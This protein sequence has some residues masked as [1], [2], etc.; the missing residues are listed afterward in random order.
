MVVKSRKVERQRPGHR[1]ASPDPVEV[2]GSAKPHRSKAWQWH[3]ALLL[4]AIGAIYGGFLDTPFVFDDWGHL[5]DGANLRKLTDGQVWNLGSRW[6]GS[7]TFAVNYA[8]HGDSVVGYHLVNVAIHMLAAVTLYAIVDWTL[9]TSPSC[10]AFRDQAAWLAFAVALLWSVHPLH[11]Q[12]VTYL[13]QR[14][15]SLASLFYLLAFWALLQTQ[16]STKPKRWYV[17]SWA[18]CFLSMA[19]KEIGATA[20]VMLLWFDRA[21]LAENWGEIR[22]RRWGYY[23]LLATVWLMPA[24][25]YGV[26]GQK[27]VSEGFVA[28]KSDAALTA[29]V[30]ASD[31]DADKHVVD[32]SAGSHFRVG[33]TPSRWDYLI[34]QPAVLLR[35]VRLAFLPTGQ[36]FDQAWPPVSNWR[37]AAMP[38]LVVLAILMATTYGASRG[39]RWAFLSGWFFITI[40]PASSFVPLPDLYFEHRMYLPLIA[41]VVATVLVA[42]S[43]G[44]AG[45]SRFGWSR[46]QVRF[47][48]R[49]ALALAAILLGTATIGRNTVYVSEI[50]LWADTVVKA[51]HNSRAFFNLAHRLQEADRHDEAAPLYA[52]AARLQ[53]GMPDCHNNLGESLIRLGEFSAARRELETALQLAPGYPQAHNN[54][55]VLLMLVGDPVDEAV[56]HFRAA[57]DGVPASNEYRENL[58]RALAVQTDSPAPAAP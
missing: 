43:L 12:A 55:G 13:V 6:F 37:E 51:P 34:S 24:W 10:A 21:F 50:S 23:L 38:G 18:A 40:S 14:F 42:S 7:L 58:R 46:G 26:L 8:I 57:V 48:G 27:S 19:T 52:R 32:I 20:P 56:E 16:S 44:R 1:Q 49:V 11:T 22:R 54:L 25:Y 30:H 53:P 3:V 31:D 45:V 28:A 29:V 17:A 2:V 33:E 5:T 35:Y 41:V 15:E 47:G 4:I 36:C 39:R 9:R